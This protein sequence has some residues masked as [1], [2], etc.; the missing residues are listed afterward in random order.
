MK[1]K[2]LVAMAAVLFTA[3]YLGTSLVR[4]NGAQDFKISGNPPSHDLGFQVPDFVYLFWLIDKN[5]IPPP[6]N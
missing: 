1:G 4:A 2:W 3:A 5:S 6:F